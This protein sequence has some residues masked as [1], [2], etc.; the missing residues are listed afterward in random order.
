MGRFKHGFVVGGLLGAGLMWL[1][2]TKKG[3]EMRST[4]LQASKDIYHEI[5]EEVLN[6]KQWDTLTQT[7]FVAR[8]T[9]L[10]DRYAVENGLAES[11]KKL[12]TKVVSNQYPKIKKKF[13]SKTSK[14]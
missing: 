11:V 14:K 5:E 7:A 3:R 13:E 1:N 9:E 6:S 10:V 8:V 4:I 2:A 12:V